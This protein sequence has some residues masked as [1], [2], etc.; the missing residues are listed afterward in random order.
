M[1]QELGRAVRGQSG[2]AVTEHWPSRVQRRC[3]WDGRISH[4]TGLLPFLLFFKYYHGNVLFMTF[5]LSNYNVG[6]ILNV[7]KACLL[8]KLY[9]ISTSST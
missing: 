7:D 6:R 1:L 3:Q 5:L 4:K 9:P 8:V 2:G